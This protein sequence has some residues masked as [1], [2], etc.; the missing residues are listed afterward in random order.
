MAR[1]Y[2]SILGL[3]CEDRREKCNYGFQFIEFDMI[4]HCT[5]NGNSLNHIKREVWPTN[6]PIGKIPCLQQQT[7]QL[8]Q[9]VFKPRHQ[10]STTPLFFVQHPLKP[11]DIHGSQFLPLT[12]RIEYKHHIQLYT[13]AVSASFTVQQ[14]IK[15]SS[16]GSI[17]TQINCPFP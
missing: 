3:W 12:L 6:Q 7:L 8:A 16:L 9:N 5:A 4:K 10:C 11:R 13:L 1:F 15:F 14:Q 17:R 2:F